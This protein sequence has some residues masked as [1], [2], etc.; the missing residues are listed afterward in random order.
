MPNTINS[1]K[2]TTD[3][4]LKSGTQVTLRDWLTGRE[5]RLI[6]NA[7]W[8]GKHMQ[9]KDGK[10]ESDPVEMEKMDASTDK[11]I[12]LMVVAINGER[13]EDVVGYVL[14][15]LPGDDYDELMDLIEDITK[16]AD[17]AKKGNGPKSTKS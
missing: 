11:T 10:G 16:P 14:D 3:F 9:V 1:S 7:I 15:E 13:P 8:A 4:T 5:K 6:K 12:E 17:K 2:P